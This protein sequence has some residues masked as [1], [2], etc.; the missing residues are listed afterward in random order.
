MVY[1]VGGIEEVDRKQDQCIRK[2]GEI[3]YSR[4]TIAGWV[5][6]RNFGGGTGHDEVN[7]EKRLCYFILAE[8]EDTYLEPVALVVVQHQQQTWTLH[9]CC[10]GS[11]GLW[12]DNRALWSVPVR[13]NM[14]G[15]ARCE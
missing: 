13:P 7:K 4:S 6:K 9:R 12:F 1:V 11:C 3:Y 2:T 15:S 10:Q 14:K 8:R 5:C